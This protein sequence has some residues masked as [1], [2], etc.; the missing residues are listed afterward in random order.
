[1]NPARLLVLAGPVALLLTGCVANGPADGDQ[2]LTVES[3][4]DACTL[5]ANHAPSGTL[6]FSVTNTGDQVTEFYLLA[7]DG[8]RIIAEVENIAPGLT[9]DLVAQV[10]AGEYLT[11]CKPG[12]AGD[13]IQAAFTVT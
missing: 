5:S 12:M 13:G 4:A 6:T 9:R 11:A 10:S 1:M 3:S 8:L 7:A 2:T